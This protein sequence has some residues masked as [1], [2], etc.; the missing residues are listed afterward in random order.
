MRNSAVSVDS[1][2]KERTR[3]L[4]FVRYYLPGYRGGGPIRT[5]AN[6][7]EQLGDELEFHVVC[8][9]REMGGAEPFSGVVIDGWNQVGKARVFYC[10]RAHR[11]LPSIRRLMQDTPH[12]VLYFNS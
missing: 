5:I 11:S 10:S 4:V 2:S 6:L 12:D 1:M 8:Q 3:V 9:D 7:V